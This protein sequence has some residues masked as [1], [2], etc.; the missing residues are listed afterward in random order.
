MTDTTVAPLSKFCTNPHC[1]HQ[2]QRQL[3]S[4]FYVRSGVNTPTAPGHYLSECIACMRRRN[5]T[6][7]HLPDTEPRAFTETIAI[8]YLREH[9]IHALPGKAV[10]AAHVDLVAWGAVWIEVKYAKLEQRGNQEYFT[11]MTTRKQNQ[12][13]F[14][15]HLVLL[16]C[17]YPDEKR[18]YHLFDAHEPAFYKD[19]RL[20][21]GFSFRPGATASLKPARNHSIL[22]QEMMDTAENRLS[23]IP[24]VMRRISGELREKHGA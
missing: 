1:E 5:E 12:R 4:A 6:A 18:R 19:G 15:G 21:H 13:G 2:G 9:G 24:Q 17:E 22:L 10:A 23:L 16:I 14:L 20:K 3:V 7:L 11:F 8:S